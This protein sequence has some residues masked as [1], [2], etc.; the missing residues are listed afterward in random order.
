[1]TDNE[2]EVRFPGMRPLQAMP[3]LGTI[4]GCGLS[5]YGARDHDPDTFTY[6][7]TRYLTLLYVPVLALSAYRAAEVTQGLF[8]LGR[9]PLS[10]AA[11][12]WN[13]L[14]LV[15]L[16]GVS[17]FLAWDHHSRSPG[18]QLAQ[19]DGLVRAGQIAAAARLYQ[20]VALGS[21][22]RAPEAAERLRA[23]L[24]GPAVEAPAVEAAGVFQAAVAARKR[25]G[26]FADLFDR[27]L[28]RVK[29]DAPTDPR[30]ALAV[31]EAVAPLGADAAA[32]LATRRQLLERIVAQEPADPE[33]ASQLAVVYEAQGELARCEPLLAPHAG[34]LG[35]REGARILGQLYVHQDKWEQAHALLLPY[36]EGRLQRLHA[37]QKAFTDTLTRAQ[38]Q[39]LD[40]IKQRK[41][42]DYCVLKS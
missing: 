42:K 8:L 4:Y 38:D 3:A 22:D 31:L 27:G 20:D 23:L 12:W 40:Q 24:E 39:V 6:V 25:H 34:Q 14:V 17:G 16:L 41:A 18:R 37:A 32:L 30:G 13:R 33:P 21:T 29:R 36:T 26:G 1:M 35:L 28:E 19:A 11:K 10:A 7:K 2:W 9:V 5:L 15:A